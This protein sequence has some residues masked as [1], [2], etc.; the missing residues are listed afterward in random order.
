MKKYL[1]TILILFCAIQLIAQYETFPVDLDID[2]ITREM[3]VYLPSSYQQGDVLPLVINM[4]G[5]GSNSFQQNFYSGFNAVA[6]T[7]N[8]IVIYPQGLVDTTS[9]GTIGTHWAAYFGTDTDDMSFMH[10][11]IDW[12][13]T[14]HN[15]DL[16]R[17][18]ATGMS[19]GGFM[20]YRLACEMSER[21]AA[22]ASVTGSMAL[23]QFDNCSPNRPVPIMEIHGTADLTVPYDGVSGFIPSIPSI[24]DFWVGHNQCGA[25]VL[26]DFPNINTD[27]MSTVSSTSYT[28][29]QDGTEVLLYTVD[30]GGHSWP[31]AYV[32]PDF[33][34]TNLDIDASDHIWEFFTRH[35]HPDPAPAEI[36]TTDVATVYTKEFAVAPNPFKDFIQIKTT[37][38]GKASIID[39]RGKLLLEKEISSTDFQLQT[40]GLIP[41]MYLLMIED[42][43]GNRQ[44][45]KIIKY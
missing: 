9:F 5:F 17:V 35:A 40:T 33:G 7:H 24:I 36:L 10:T 44:T 25:P 4:H 32:F 21:I 16:S 1:H 28:D 14:F 13:Y 20:S 8:F 30:N 42:K 19:N 37:G 3:D 2:G 15:I 34:P 41:G 27:D 43:T 45:I 23:A 11:I 31:G 29:C 39:M 6:E 38:S 12:S 26:S 22:I 18:Y